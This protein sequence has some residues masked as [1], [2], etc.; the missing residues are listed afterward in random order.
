MNH[1]TKLP[2]LSRLFLFCVA[3]GGRQRPDGIETDHFLMIAVGTQFL[4]PGGKIIRLENEGHNVGVGAS[5]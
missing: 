3:L 2:E 1:W 5:A 4:H